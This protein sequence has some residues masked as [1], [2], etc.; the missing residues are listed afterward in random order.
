MHSCRFGEIKKYF[1]LKKTAPVIKHSNLQKNV[2]LGTAALDH[3]P[4]FISCYFTKIFVHLLIIAA[5]C[6]ILALQINR[7]EIFTCSKSTRRTLKKSVAGN[8]FKVNNRATVS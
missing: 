8:M 2:I 7:V 6:V 3:N 4:F 1:P 5:V